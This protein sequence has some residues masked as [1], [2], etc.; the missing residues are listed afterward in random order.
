MDGFGASITDSSAH[1]LSTLPG[2]V[3]DGAM[4]DLFSP[5]QGNGL[6][7]LRQ[8]M[9]ASD[10]VA[11]EFYTYDDVGPGQTDYGMR[12]FTIAHDQRQILPLLRQAWRLNPKLKVIA[13]PWSPP[14]WMKTNKSL[15]GGRLIDDPRIYRAYASYFVK[16]LQAYQR[17]GVGIYAVAVQNEPQNR[18][19]RGYPTGPP[20]CPGSEARQRA[21]AGAS[22]RRAEHQDPRVRP[23]LVRAPGRCC[24]HALW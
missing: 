6:S 10:F 11:G 2:A 7:V 5:T 20:R 3:R 21:P 1:V 16:Y 23:Q 13:T 19:P 4:R 14:A 12:R 17:A 24:V 9:G 8:P 18:N 22:G 15:V